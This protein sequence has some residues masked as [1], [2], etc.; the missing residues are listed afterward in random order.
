MATDPIR[1]IR[2]TAIESIAPPGI[3]EIMRHLAA[4]PPSV[5]VPYLTL[6]LDWRIDGADP[7]IRPARR[8]VEREATAIIDAFAPRG[9]AYDSLRADVARIRDYLDHELDPGAQGAVIVAHSAS[10]VF[11][12][13]P[14]P[15]PLPTALHVAPIPSLRAL[16]HLVEDHPLYAVLLADQRTAFLTLV[17]LGAANHTVTVRGSDYPRKQQTGGWSQRR[18]QARAGERV[19]AFARGVAGAVRRLLDETGFHALVI[20]GDEVFTSAFD[21]VVHPTVAALTIARIRLDINAT[22][23]DI[24]SATTPIVEERERQREEEAV[25]QVIG[26]LASGHALTG[27]SAVLRALQ[28]G[29]VDTMVMVDDVQASGWADFSLGV[30]GAGDIPA[31]HPAAGDLQRIVTIDLEDHV[32]WLA[33]LTGAE[34][35][36]IH[37]RMP[38]MADSSLPEPG[39]PAPRTR[40]A[41][42]LDE[43]GGIGAV[44]RFAVR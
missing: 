21:A 41:T 24:V 7:T 5:E 40:A 13:I 3:Q 32:I 2:A 8:Q 43:V 14:L 17:S 27:A 25:Q 18:F 12:P 26:G 11:E 38:V 30:Y 36:I 44:L 33:L 6:T 10:G 19:A 4:L 9:P 42:R 31:T 15:L 22:E 34:I 16:A 37:S 29:R 1:R 39:T 28:E 35:E 23:Q 20:A